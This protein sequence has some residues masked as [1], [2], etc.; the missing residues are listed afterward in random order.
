[1]RFVARLQLAVGFFMLALLFLRGAV[2]KLSTP[3]FSLSLASAKNPALVFIGLWLVLLPLTRG[4]TVHRTR[5]DLPLLTLL[6]LSLVS[7][8]FSTYRWQS[9]GSVL[10]VALYY[11]FYRAM[12]DFARR[13]GLVAPILLLLVAVATLVAGIDLAY[14]VHQGLDQVL[15]RYPFW[16]GKNALGLFLALT[17][18]MGVSWLYFAPPQR[19]P[20]RL[21]LGAACGVIFLGLAFTYARAAWLG[22]AG[23]LVVLG[24][25]RRGRPSREVSSRQERPADAAGGGVR[26]STRRSGLPRLLPLGLLALVAAVLVAVVAQP[27]A[28]QRVTSALT[29]QD[30]N[31]RDRLTLW[32]AALAMA[33][34]R[35]I[36]GVGVGT[37]RLNYRDRYKGPLTWEYAAVHAHN[38]YLHILAELGL[39]GLVALLWLAVAALRGALRGVRAAS[40]PLPR[41][42]AAGLAAVLCVSAIESLFESSFTGFVSDMSFIHINLVLGTLFSLLPPDAARAPAKAACS[43][44]EPGGRG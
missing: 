1:M 3:W 25:L 43:A 16:P 22:A 42:V 6:G 19:R 40:L 32:R 41:A 11:A 10:V 37:F 27:A 28:R 14:H 24:M 7:A 2:L 13:P 4:A 39:P 29:L 34:D 35:P 17:L 30:P 38:L 15:E 18:Q 5:L 8:L 9:L 23:G 31:V 12:S 20:A 26:G 36:T 21:A 44:G 33:A